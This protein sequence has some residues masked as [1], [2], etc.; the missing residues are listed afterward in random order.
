MYG[1]HP[2][3][4]NDNLLEFNTKCLDLMSEKNITPT[5][6]DWW[7]CPLG[8]ICLEDQTSRPTYYVRLRRFVEF[9]LT[10]KDDYGDSLL[11]FHR[12]FPKGKGVICA[13]AVS[14]FMLSIYTKKGHEV[15]DM[16][17]KTIQV[18]EQNSDPK[19]TTRRKVPMLGTGRWN[20]PKACVGLIS[21]IG[22]IVRTNHGVCGCYHDGCEECAE[23]FR[24]SSFQSCLIHAGSP[25]PIRYGNTAKAPILVLTLVY[26]KK[27]YVHV[28]N[29]TCQLLPSEIRE[30]AHYLINGSHYHFG[31][32]VC[33]LLAVDNFLRKME[34]KHLHGDNFNT[35]MHVMTD[36]FT[37]EGL[38][39]KVRG[40][41]TNSK[42]SKEKENEEDCEE[43]GEVYRYLYIWGDDSY[44][45][46]DTKSLLLAYLY[47]IGWKGGYLFPSEKELNDRPAD[48]VYL[49]HVSDKH[50][51]GELKHLYKVV[52][53]RKDKLCT[54]TMRKTAYLM[55]IIRGATIEEC[56]RAA[57]HESIKVAKKYVQGASAVAS[58]N[59]VI[60]DP[61]MKLGTYKSC[62]CEGNETAVKVT[63]YTSKHQVP[64]A[65]LVVGFIEQVVGV[66][67]NDRQRK[68]PRFLYNAIM[69]LPYPSRAQDELDLH[70]KDIT[71]IKKRALMRSIEKH[72]E[73]QKRALR[74]EY[75]S[76]A[77]DA[78]DRD[79]AELQA[80]ISV[81]VE[82]GLPASCPK[83]RRTMMQSLGLDGIFKRAREGIPISPIQEAQSSPLTPLASPPLITPRKKRRGTEEI[84][85]RGCI[86]KLPPRDRL[87]FI[88]KF[89][90]SNP[91]D[92][93]DRDRAW[94]NRVKGVASCYVNCCGSS[95]DSFMTAHNPGGEDFS[96]KK[97]KELKFAGCPNCRETP[98]P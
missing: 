17:G 49:T 81:A 63:N 1:K 5:V 36:K 59:A 3:V 48:G 80:E 85:D 54:H 9:L 52:L 18:F 93:I 55:S 29:P 90:D 37:P 42:K 53:C 4:S 82:Q 97:I 60:K 66:S 72:F 24:K 92:Y 62:H 2:V 31:I 83:K 71:G 87:T 6:E 30:M 45:E 77:R 78:K 96:P 50:F 74:L 34:F 69:N 14:H 41:K 38:N 68:D 86:S 65:E 43:S 61:M 46:F 84:K 73:E 13:T 7:Y 8:V 19:A 20:D 67:S 28:G 47:S 88:A 32:Y 57:G 91:G 51:M 21:A 22:H 98:S 76:L 39:H 75:E 12:R 95:F 16:E 27:T 33:L 58:V 89:A 79:L 70:L 94:L 23:C 44:R 56:M 25:E 26:L 10:H 35:S 15:K 11:P 64:L 40:K